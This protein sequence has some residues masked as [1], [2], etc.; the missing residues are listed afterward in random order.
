[1]HDSEPAYFS[2]VVRNHLHAT[3]PGRWIGRDVPVTWTLRSP[4]FNP[5]NFFLWGHLESLVYA[6]PVVTVEDLTA[7]IVVTSSDIDRVLE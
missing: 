6:T 2:I 1:M 4:D 3:Y 5:L 7:R